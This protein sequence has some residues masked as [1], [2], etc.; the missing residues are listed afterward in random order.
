MT[1]FLIGVAD[2]IR[3]KKGTTAKI[4]PQNFETEIGSIETGG[5]NDVAR[6]TINRTVETVTADDLRGATSIGDYVFYDCTK[7]TNITIPNSVT[8]IGEDAF[9][10]CHSLTSVTIPNSVISIGNSAFSWCDAIMNITIP[11]SVTSIGNTAFSNCFKLI[12]VIMLPTTPPKLGEYVFDTADTIAVPVGCG[13]AYKT[14]D[15]WKNYANKIVE[16]TV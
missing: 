13:E 3:T 6:K 9:H 11:D 4:N 14:A 12:K 2:A 7:L 5:M 15:G 8:S 16:E 1:D 10:F